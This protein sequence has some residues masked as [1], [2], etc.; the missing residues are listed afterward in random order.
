MVAIHN[1]VCAIMSPMHRTT[2][3]LPTDLKRKAQQLAHHRGISFGE[4]VRESLEAA[5]A[6]HGGEI[7]E[8]LL[9]SDTAVYGGPAPSSLS[10]DHDDFLYGEPET[11]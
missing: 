4:L 5:L 10:T 11:S 3:M 7:R 6:S 8:D 2:V 9:F 1:Y